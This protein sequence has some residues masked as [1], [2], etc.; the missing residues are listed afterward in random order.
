MLK[1]ADRQDVNRL[2]K[3]RYEIAMTGV[4]LTSDDPAAI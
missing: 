4:E 1:T 2:E 3:G